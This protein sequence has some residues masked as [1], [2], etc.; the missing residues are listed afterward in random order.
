MIQAPEAKFLFVWSFF[1]SNWKVFG[2]QPCNAAFK[3]IR[4]VKE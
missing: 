4:D 2:V 1:F 3:G